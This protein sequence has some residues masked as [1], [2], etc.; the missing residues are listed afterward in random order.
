MNTK[1]SLK[2]L[3]EELKPMGWLQRIDHIWTYY[4]EVLL[5]ALL[6]VVIAIGFI[7][8]FIQANK[9]NLINGMMVNITMEQ[10]GYNYLTQDFGEK[11]I[12]QDDEE[13]TLEYTEFLS[14]AD[15]TSNEDNYYAAMT[16]IAEVSAKRLEY[17]IQDK[18]SLEFYLTQDVFMDLQAF[19]TPEELAQWEDKLVYGY[20]EDTD[21]KWVAAVDITDLPYVR[22]NVT[23]EGP[24][25]FSLGGSTEKTDMCRKMWEH[26]LAWESKQ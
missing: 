5:L 4:K 25:Y 14:M 1:E 16:V 3:V 18:L 11:V 2:K 12:T 19:F 22:D 23:S 17:V 15:P 8:S 20:E 26:I 7:S 6:G 13:V 24:I 9:V 10:T 21:R